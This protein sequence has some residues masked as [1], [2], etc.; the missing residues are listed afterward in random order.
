MADRENTPPVLVVDYDAA[1]R[2]LRE[3]LRGAPQRPEL[4]VFRE[5]Y[6]R[7]MQLRLPRPLAVRRVR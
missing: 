3:L 7:E 5:A 1:E 4:G 6:A 2:R